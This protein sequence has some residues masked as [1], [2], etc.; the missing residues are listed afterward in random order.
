M[1]KYCSPVDLQ[2]IEGD[3]DVKVTLFARLLAKGASSIL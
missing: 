1:A 3:Q 2:A